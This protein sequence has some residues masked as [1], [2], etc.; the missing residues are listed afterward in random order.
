[1]LDFWFLFKVGCVA[2]DAQ[3]I[4]RTVMAL[5]H[6]TSLNRDK[7]KSV[8]TF[9][10]LKNCI[11]KLRGWVSSAQQCLPMFSPCFQRFHRFHVRLAAVAWRGRVDPVV[12]SRHSPKLRPHRHDGCAS[13]CAERTS[14]V[15]A[16]AAV[17]VGQ[18]ASNFDHPMV[19]VGFR[20]PTVK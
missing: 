4:Q 6:P 1:M 13:R 5:P 11:L 19:P 17:A 2:L 9:S 8:R 12:A 20:S 3:Q 10:Q 7:Y 16:A 15:L 18:T 14:V